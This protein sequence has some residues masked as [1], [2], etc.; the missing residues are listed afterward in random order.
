MEDRFRIDSHKLMF[1]VERVNNWLKGKQICPIYMEIAPSGGCNHRCIF[2]AL[3]YLGY[4]PKFLD[5]NVLKDAVRQAGNLGVKSIMYAGEGEPLLHKD[6]C[7]IV[8]FT[9]NC[10]IDVAITTNGV[11]LKKDIS[12]KILKYLSWIKVS[13]NAGT[14]RTY[15]KIHRIEEGDFFKVMENL[16]D[17]VK[18]KKKNR[19]ETAIG[20]QLL[21]IP[22][23]VK[24]VVALA[25]ILKNI[26]VD[27]L[28][29]KP[30]SQH[31]LSSSRIDPAFKYEHISV[32]KKL[33]LLED[34]RFKIVFR[35]QTMRRLGIQKDY[36]RC[37]GA[38]FWAYIDSNGEMS[39]CC[40]FLGRDDF[41]FGNINKDCFKNI[42]KSKRR[43]FVLSRISSKINV[44]KC[45]E[46]C[47]LDKINSYL[48]EL[49]NPD[50]H[51]NF[52]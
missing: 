18:I 12:Q 50:V 8:K 44:D 7:E 10:C 51:V 48:W 35:Y 39:A 5:L 30:Y 21:L 46:V 31:P 19:L 47:R 33:R 16:R 20:V 13:L 15:S 36:K 29:V 52:I 26:G 38:P 27:Y 34:D 3:D 1:H 9:K 23:N 43:R 41:G 17:A 6:I 28:V 2:C 14:S 24:E 37:L 25:R 32:H 22:D 4:K 11:L 40:A 49:N 42:I 45:R